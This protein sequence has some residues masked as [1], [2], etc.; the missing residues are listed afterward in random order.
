VKKVA[1]CALWVWACAPEPFTSPGG[2][3]LG[4]GPGASQADLCPAGLTRIYPSRFAG[5]TGASTPTAGT[6]GSAFPI[7][8]A[9]DAGTDAGDDAG[10]PDASVVADGGPKDVIDA[11]N[12]DDGPPMDAGA[13]MTVVDAGPMPIADAG[14][15]TFEPDGGVHCAMTRCGT[16]QVAVEDPTSVYGSPN[17]ICTSPPPR[18]SGGQWAQ[19]TVSGHWICTDCSVLIHYGGIFG[20]VTRCAPAPTASQCGAGEVPTFD[21]TQEAWQCAPKCDNGLY[22]QVMLAGVLVCVPC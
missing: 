5:E 19:Y 2:A 3:G 18:C 17:L 11:G 22:D 13:V 14:V 12:P 15:A 9:P 1:C 4:S 10:S 16:A 6:A 7:P 21:A 20:G 8:R